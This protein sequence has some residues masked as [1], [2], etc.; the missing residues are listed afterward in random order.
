MSTDFDIEYNDEESPKSFLST[1]NILITL[2]ATL[3][4]S[5]LVIRGLY[6]RGYFDVATEVP[7]INPESINTDDSGDD[8]DNSRYEIDPSFQLEDLFFIHNKNMLRVIQSQ[9]E[10]K[11]EK[12]SVPVIVHTTVP[13][14]S[15]DKKKIYFAEKDNIDYYD[16]ETEITEKTP[17]HNDDFLIVS[18]FVLNKPHLNELICVGVNRVADTCAFRFFDLEC[19]QLTNRFE[20]HHCNA[21][22]IPIIR[23]LSPD[24]A[25]LFYMCHDTKRMLMKDLSKPEENDTFIIESNWDC[26]FE[27]SP[28]NEKLIRY[29]SSEY[30]YLA[31]IDINDPTNV[32]VIELK[33]NITY[34]HRFAFSKNQKI[35]Y[36]LAN[37]GAVKNDYELFAFDYEKLLTQSKAVDFF[38]KQVIKRPEDVVN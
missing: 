38:S 20:K 5:L 34:I 2:G 35:L 15:K 6:A 10:L 13:Q 18:N 32:E 1:R 8:N 23:T 36:V 29:C 25:R 11:C 31:L 16:L 33:R 17:I 12:I 4:V 30:N 24:G 28:D 19:G 21:D 37:T 14:Y 9:N 22:E 7:I 3:A 27:I 26:R